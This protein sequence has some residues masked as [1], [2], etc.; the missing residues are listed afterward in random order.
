MI[1]RRFSPIRA[2][3]YNPWRDFEFL[4]RDMLRL[5]DAASGLSS[6]PAAPGVFPAVNVSQDAE[7]F[8]IHA[9]VPG[10]RAEDIDISA[11]NR[12]VTLTGKR[13]ATP[14]EGA[15]YH[16]RER[17]EGEFKRSVTLP[18][19]FDHDKVEA[20]LSHGVLRITLPKPESVKPRQIAIKTA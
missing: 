9:E 1:V 10:V 6:E 17:L 3:L 2:N 19:D 7:K 18:A 4:R 13:V 20:N 11:A 16:R 8:T 15:S 12:T 14:D 5:L